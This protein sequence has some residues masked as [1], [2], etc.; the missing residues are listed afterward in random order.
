MSKST[1]LPEQIL[2]KVEEF[3]EL[4][5]RT[6]IDPHMFEH[7]IQKKKYKNLI[8]VFQEY[9]NAVSPWYEEIIDTIQVEDISIF[10]KY[11]WFRTD[12]LDKQRKEILTFLK[13]FPEFRANDIKTIARHMEDALA[14]MNAL[15][16]NIYLYINQIPI[17]GGPMKKPKQELPFPPL[18]PLQSGGEQLNFKT[19]P[20]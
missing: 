4:L 11:F 20:S 6:E 14:Q 1:L 2:K 8:E 16:N 13:M 18:V 10:S 9:A 7:I 3:R 17:W 15:N 19:T 5:C 12:T